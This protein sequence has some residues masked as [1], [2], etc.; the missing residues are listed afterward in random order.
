LQAVT[1]YVS[2]ALRHTEPTTDLVI[3]AEQ[4]GSMVRIAVTDRGEG[5]DPSIIGHVFE[6]FFRVDTGRARSSGGAGLGLAIVA[7]IVDAQNGRCGVDSE[8]GH[9]STFWIEL[10]LH[11]QQIR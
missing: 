2:N 9:G 11:E 1:A 7:A 3:S 6:R 4:R 10:P 5:I 8:L